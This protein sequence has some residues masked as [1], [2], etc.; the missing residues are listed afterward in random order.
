ML[1]F[2]KLD[3]I[4][5]ACTGMEAFSM[6]VP[7]GW[8]FEGGLRWSVKNTIM[9]AALG[10][11]LSGDSVTVQAIPGHAF[12]WTDL[13][14]IRV[15]HPIG[16]KYL[17]AVVCPV[18]EPLDVINDIIVPSLRPDAS[19]IKVVEEGPVDR[20]EGSMG[21]DAE[22]KSFARSS[23]EGARTRLEYSLDGREMEEEIFCTVTVF[24]FNV[25][26]RS[27]DL[28]Y[29]F[30]MADHMYTFSA[31]KGKLEHNMDTLQTIMH[32]FTV[33]PA[34]FEKYSRI[35]L[36][37]KDRQAHRQSSLRQLSMDV[38]LMVNANVNEILRPYAQRHT[39]NKWVAG[40]LDNGEHTDEYYDPIQQ[41]C[42]RLP[43]GFDHAWASG[44]GEYLLSNKSDFQP[45]SGFTE[46]W[47]MMEKITVETPREKTPAASVL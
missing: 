5:R 28:G 42:V 23:T 36:Y 41:I 45:D 15:S 40:H 9:P 43:S 8:S 37:L 3:H 32:S 11:K 26:D 22:F 10:F 6:L 1:R 34:W 17:G 16:S 38:D 44:T 12:F 29:I 25:S 21:F 14:Y 47:K 2:N 46:L 35:V 19:G 7:S 18:L 20:L 27:D 24:H 31:E 30:W 33:N 39:A 4:D 13:P